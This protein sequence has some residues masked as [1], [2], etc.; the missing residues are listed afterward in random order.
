MKRETP[1]VSVEE[2][3]KMVEELQHFGLENNKPDITEGMVQQVKFGHIKKLRQSKPT[4][5]FTQ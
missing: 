5:F 3:R 4:N 1:A 2:A